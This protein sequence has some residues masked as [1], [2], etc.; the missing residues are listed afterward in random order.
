VVGLSGE[1]AKA[2]I[3]KDDPTIHTFVLLE[4]SI[5]TQDYKIDRVRIFTNA[6]GVVVRTPKRG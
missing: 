6:D 2:I 3:L 4:G 1:E 5:V